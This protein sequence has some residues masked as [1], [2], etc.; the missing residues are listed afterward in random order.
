MYQVSDNIMKTWL[1]YSKKGTVYTNHERHVVEMKYT[2]IDKTR[3]ILID[4][5]N[6]NIPENSKLLLSEKY[7]DKRKIPNKNW[8]YWQSPAGRLIDKKGFYV[9]Y[10]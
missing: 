8:I 3:I 7:G 9:L 4:N 10:K 1:F 5:F 2:V 6:I